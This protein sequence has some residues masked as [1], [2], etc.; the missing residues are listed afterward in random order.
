MI[1]C[2]IFV[3]I[4]IGLR[5]QSIIAERLG[6]AGRAVFE[7]LRTC[8]SAK[9]ASSYYMPAFL[10]PTLINVAQWVI[11]DVAVFIH[12]MRRQWVCRKVKKQPKLAPLTM[13][14]GS[15]MLKWGLIA[16]PSTKWQK[17]ET[18]NWASNSIKW[19]TREKEI[20]WRVLVPKS[21]NFITYQ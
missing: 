19:R 6:A 2:R 8:E 11:F 12:E 4:L 10:C 21:N 7:S 13:D 14:T 15:F 3:A 1:R 18:E 20:C 9:V 17:S 5:V 16:P